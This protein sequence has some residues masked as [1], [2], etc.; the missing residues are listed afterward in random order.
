MDAGVK[1]AFG[2]V[3]WHKTNAKRAGVVTGII[4]RESGFTIM[5]NWGED[6]EAEHFACELTTEQDEA[7]TPV[8]VE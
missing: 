3:V 4:T 2:Q 5:V 1:F 6:G 7:Q 8:S